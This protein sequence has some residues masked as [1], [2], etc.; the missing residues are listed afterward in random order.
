MRIT[1]IKLQRG[2]SSGCTVTLTVPLPV[3][4]TPRIAGLFGMLGTVAA[5]SE[6]DAARRRKVSDL[7]L[8]TAA[9]FVA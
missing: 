6:V 9:A 7:G 4:L 5:V 8:T 1:L 3:H 2:G